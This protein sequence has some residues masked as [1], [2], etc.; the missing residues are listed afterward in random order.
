ME[1]VLL[2]SDM[3]LRLGYAAESFRNDRDGLCCKLIIP[4]CSA[5]GDNHLM[6]FKSSVAL[7]DYAGSAERFALSQHLTY[8][9]F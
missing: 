1:D 9:H 7:K 2:G 8:N 5:S 4:M 3:Y 6:Q